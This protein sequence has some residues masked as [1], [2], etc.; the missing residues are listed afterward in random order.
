MQRQ[1]IFFKHRC[2][3]SFVRSVPFVKKEKKN[4]HKTHPSHLDM[5]SQVGE[6]IGLWWSVVFRLSRQL[7]PQWNSC[8]SFTERGRKGNVSSVLSNTQIWEH[9][10]NLQEPIWRRHPDRRCC[11][12]NHSR[13]GKKKKSLFFKQSNLR[14]DI[15]KNTLFTDVGERSGRF[16]TRSL[17]RFKNPSERGVTRALWK[18]CWIVCQRLSERNKI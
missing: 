5:V 13:R 12:I 11:I 7:V 15:K 17:T 18:K 6:M 8:N 4:E 2:L 16:D 10:E 14:A 1:T 3:L 9:E